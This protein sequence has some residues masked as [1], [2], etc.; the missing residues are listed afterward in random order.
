MKSVIE[1]VLRVIA[2][3]W[4]IG[5]VWLRRV[6]I[7]AIAVPLG[8]LA[9][10]MLIPQDLAATV[11]PIL[12][13]LPVAAI[14]VIALQKPMVI[15]TATTAEVGRK[16]IRAVSLVLAAD[17]VFGIFLSLVPISNDP[18]LV[19]LF[20]L[21][22]VTILLLRIGN[23]RG[24]VSGLLTLLAIGLTV[25]FLIGGRSRMG[26]SLK[27]LGTAARTQA[28][29]Q[30]QV[31]GG[32]NP[33]RICENAWGGGS[34][35]RNDNVEYF[36]VKLRPGCW[37][38]FIYLPKSWQNWYHEP[39]G[40]TNGWW[41]SLWYSG[42]PEGSGPYEAGNISTVDFRN[43]PPILRLQGNGTIRF[44]S[45]V[46]PENATPAQS[47]SAAEERTVKTYHLTPTSPTSGEPDGYTF[48]IED[49]YRS[50]EQIK[51]EGKATNKT[52][53][54][55]PLS[56]YDSHAVDDE[57]NSIGIWTTGGQFMF[58]GAN[59]IYGGRERLLPGVPTK[60]LVTIDDPHRN[61]KTIN[62]EL[63][64]HW[65]EDNRSDKL[66]FEGVPVQ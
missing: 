26:G 58:P 49:C 23:A 20:V 44:Y 4:N 1:E 9:A 52:D 57:G 48:V 27:S 32:Y 61:V 62:L 64:T 46:A 40:D 22:L 50:G 12:A 55:T 30:S 36:D 21:A 63:S 59:A 54:T 8:M 45:N 28:A 19:P 15:A 11:I 14:V 65:S 10:A 31:V 66:V 56:L 7:F 13:L 34:D 5:N 29:P 41:V 37:S 51:C 18:G 6:A 53:A 24:F 17:L 33:N 47:Q 25:I 35:H 16:A 42:K 3:I 43:V 38:Q 39:V 2:S 60:F